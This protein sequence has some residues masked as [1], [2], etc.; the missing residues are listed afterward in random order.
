MGDPERLMSYLEKNKA[1]I[2]KLFNML[3]Q[4]FGPDCEIVLHD[5]TLPY[6][7]TIVDIRNG[8]VTGRTIGDGGSNLGLEVLQGSVKE[9]DRYNYITVLK[10]SRIVRS[11]S[12]YLH[13][14]DG[15][16]AACICVNQD[17]TESVRFEDYLRKRNNFSPADG[18]EPETVEFFP[19]NVQEL[20]DYLLA[21]AQKA[22][23]SPAGKLG[24]ERKIEFL[25]HLDR[26]GAFLISK[27]SEKVC[28]Y[29]GISKF[30]L[31]KHLETI[32]NGNS[33]AVAKK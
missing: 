14:D 19:D 26:K 18:K 10:S 33:A 4:Q 24:K 9:G 7:N 6:E 5:M 11:S 21:E 13:D 8:H 17:I 2:G 16:L 22:A 25:R 27:S 23:G 15:T 20:L 32:R 30:T 3:E 1:L 12:M 28:E 29:L 31:Y